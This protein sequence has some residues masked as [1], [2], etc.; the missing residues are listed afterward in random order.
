[1]P[2]TRFMTDDGVTI[3]GDHRP[4]P[5]GAPGALFLHMM[6]ATK[7]SW[8]P[9]AA[10]LASRGFTTLAIDLRGHGESTAGEG[11]ERLDHKSFT[12][13]EHQAK[14]RDVEA[15]VRFLNESGVPTS[16][17][18]VVGASIGA[19]LAIACAAAHP[20]VPAAVAL[21]PGLDYRGVRTEDVARS[22]P[23]EQKLLLAA[24]DDDEYSFMS[25]QRL[26]EA[27]PHAELQRLSGAGHGTRMFDAR[28]DFLSYVVE[29]VVRN[30][31]RA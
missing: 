6:P 11:G 14:V 24:S 22:L 26:A 17:L 5:E 12:D 3:V 7:E 27:A 16:R 4:G 8:E 25:V 31:Q 20:E 21:S 28:P 2:K 23:R 18:A 19:N 9:L 10:S 13:E 30:A 15:A 1:M 29:W